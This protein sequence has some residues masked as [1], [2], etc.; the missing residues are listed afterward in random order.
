MAVL[1]TASAQHS[2]TQHTTVCS[3]VV[4]FVY[5][6]KIYAFESTASNK[7]IVSSLFVN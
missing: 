6:V 4:A 1:S 2:D 5:F 7:L 3:F